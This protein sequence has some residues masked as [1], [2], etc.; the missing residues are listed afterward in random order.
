MHTQ[1][2]WHRTTIWTDPAGRT[3]VQA[4]TNAR[5]QTTVT[6]DPAAPTVPATDLVILLAEYMAITMMVAA[7]SA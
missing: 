3:I 1:G 2:A 7:A 5:G 6:L 4:T